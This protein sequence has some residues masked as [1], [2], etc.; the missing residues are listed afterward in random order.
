ME[1]KSK[2]MYLIRFLVCFMT[3]EY[4]LHFMYVV[5]IK[6]S[7]AWVGDT[8]A[9]IAMIGFWNLII[10]WLKV[11]FICM[12]LIY[13][14]LKISLASHSMAILPSMGFIRSGRPT[15]EHGPLYG[16]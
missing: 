5:A 3:M 1:V 6:D 10:V 8:P 16:Q 14:A 12:P 15:R 4:I 9:E 11:R 13:G 7:R 2:I